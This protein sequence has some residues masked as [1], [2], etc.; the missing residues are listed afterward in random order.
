MTSAHHHHLGGADVQS[1]DQILVFLGHG[2][3]L[4][5]SLPLGPRRAGGVGGGDAAQAHGIAV[6]VA[7]VGVFQRRW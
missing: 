3:P 6:G 2:V 7:Q 4:A 5:L 1:D